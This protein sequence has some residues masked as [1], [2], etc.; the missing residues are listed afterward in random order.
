MNFKSIVAFLVV[1][2]LSVTCFI[3]CGEPASDNGNQS[4]DNGTSEVTQEK[5]EDQ[6]AT[7]VDC[8]FIDVKPTLDGVQ[9]EEVWNTI[10]PSTIELES[11]NQVWLK[12]YY[13][14][15]NVYFLFDWISPMTNSAE[16]STAGHWYKDEE[17]SWTW[18]SK[19]DTLS[20]AWD[21]SGIPDFAETG[22]TPLCHDQS[23][24]L[25]NRYMGTDVTGDIVELWVWSPAVSGM[26]DIMASYIWI[27]PAGE[28]TE[29][30]NWDNKITWEK[31]LGEYGFFYN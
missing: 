28:D 5:P 10:E 21:L 17:G 22:C 16:D 26:K 30:P 8:N 25:D 2:A 3:S 29:D 20:V 13:D 14:N 24:V 23:N 11:G 1:F 18:D 4:T 19:M 12:S 9:D 6:T 27:D 15:D 31:F 7:I